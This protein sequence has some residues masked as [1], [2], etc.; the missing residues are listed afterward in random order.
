MILRRLRPL[1][2]AN[3]CCK[4]NSGHSIEVG[5]KFELRVLHRSDHFLAVDKPYDLVMND[6]DPDR[7][8]LAHLLKRELPDL[9]NDSFAVSLLYSE[10]TLVWTKQFYNNYYELTSGYLV[11]LPGALK[12]SPV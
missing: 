3:R 6:D 2:S 1:L 8:S 4:M 10:P 12:S 7:F 9:Y 11:A 5:D